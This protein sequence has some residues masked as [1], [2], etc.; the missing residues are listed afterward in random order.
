MFKEKNQQYRLF[1]FG[2]LTTNFIWFLFSLI[3]NTSIIPDP[4]EVYRRIPVLLGDG[5]AVHIGYSLFRIG[6]GILLALLVGVPTGISM[7]YSTRIQRYLYPFIYF[8]YPIPKTALLP[9]AMLLMG[10]R[11]G[12]KISIIFLILVFQVVVSVRDSVEQIDITTY[13]VIRSAGATRR[14]VVRH[15]TL[16]AILPNLLTSIRISL[17]TA[18]SVLFFIEG[19]GTKFGMGYYILDAWSRINYIQMY[20]GILVLALVGFLLFL[21]MDLLESYL[22]VWNKN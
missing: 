4:I 6:T 13:Q 19:Y 22:C 18:L 17:G 10:M 8:S 11:D 15:V 20:L 12:S 7:A 5:I 21:M 2:F 1:L 3:Y 9:V 16:P 14:D